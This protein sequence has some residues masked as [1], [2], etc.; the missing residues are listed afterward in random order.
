MHAN[1]RSNQG[2]PASSRRRPK[3]K[4]ASSRLHIMWPAMVKHTIR[5]KN[6]NFRDFGIN[7][8]GIM[9]RTQSSKKQVLNRL[10]A[11]VMAS[12]MYTG[13]PRATSQFLEKRST[14]VARTEH[15]MFPYTSPRYVIRAA[16]VQWYGATVGRTVRPPYIYNSRTALPF[17]WGSFRLAPI[18]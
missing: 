3:W 18:I 16:T 14:E 1:D 11:R 4:K 8:C 5:K 9:C 12:R 13:N 10:L 6:W 2:Y 7:V 15:S 17:M